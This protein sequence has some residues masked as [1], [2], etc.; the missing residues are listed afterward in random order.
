MEVQPT[1]HQSQAKATTTHAHSQCNEPA[2]LGPGKVPR[3]ADIVDHLAQA[4]GFGNCGFEMLGAAQAT[5]S[6]RARCQRRSERRARRGPVRRTV[7][8]ASPD[9]ARGLGGC[10]EEGAASAFILEFLLSGYFRGPKTTFGP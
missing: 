8:P 10:E 2:Q 6:G 5:L 4:A 9:T 7:R 1:G 3:G